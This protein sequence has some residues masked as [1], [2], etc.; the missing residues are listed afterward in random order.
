MFLSMQASKSTNTSQQKGILFMPCGINTRYPLCTCHHCLPASWHTLFLSLN[1]HLLCVSMYIYVDPHDNKKV[2]LLNGLH[3][4]EGL[5]SIYYWYLYTYILLN[6]V[7][8]R[9]NYVQKIR[10]KFDWWFN[11]Y[12]SLKVSKRF[13]MHVYSDGTNKKTWVWYWWFDPCCTYWEKWSYCYM[14]VDLCIGEEQQTLVHGLLSYKLHKRVH[15]ILSSF[16]YVAPDLLCLIFIV[17]V[18]W[19]FTYMNIPCFAYYTARLVKINDKRLGFLNVGISVYDRVPALMYYWPS[20]YF[21]YECI[22]VCTYIF[23]FSSSLEYLDTLLSSTLWEI[24]VIWLNCLFLEVYGHHYWDLVM[25]TFSVFVFCGFIY[26]IHIYVHAPC[27]LCYIH[28]P[29]FLFQFFSD[30]F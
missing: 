13:K 10:G 11:N 18:C 12:H 17:R 28:C 20:L 21:M 26:Y 4:Y 1:A 16:M 27:N 19:T 3:A 5:L 2:T 7:H 9:R 29:Q 22:C 30:I 14:G 6:L 15:T 23:S 8:V 24:V 25:N